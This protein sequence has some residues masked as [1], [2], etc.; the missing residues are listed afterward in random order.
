MISLFISYVRATRVGAVLGATCRGHGGLAARAGHK[1][2]ISSIG[3]RRRNSITT[4]TGT[5]SDKMTSAIA[6]PLAPRGA[7]RT[8]QLDVMYVF[9]R[10][11]VGKSGWS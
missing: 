7:A 1:L 5:R 6:A 9:L 10:R 11:G 3:Q 8:R 4:I 2:T